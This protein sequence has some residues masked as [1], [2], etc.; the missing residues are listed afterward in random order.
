[1][2]ESK[3]IKYKKKY[4]E[5][6]NKINSNLVDITNQEVQ[7]ID[8][9]IKG[10]VHCTTMKNFKKI[11]KGGYIKSKSSF[12]SDINKWSGFNS[13]LVYTNIWVKTDKYP[14]SIWGTTD[15]DKDDNDRVCIIIDKYILFDKDIYFYINPAGEYGDY[16]EGTILGPN[17]KKLLSS[18]NMEGYIDSLTNDNLKM[19]LIFLLDQLKG[20]KD[21]INKTIDRLGL[22]LNIWHEVCFID[23]IDIREYF[24]GVY[25]SCN[26]I[27]EISKIVTRDMIICT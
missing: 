3:Y 25:T 6:K 8:S 4:L 17:I 9:N 14:E 2:Y 21:T 1:M 18:E 20:S 22:E 23:K 27:D 5:L 16:G 10:L 15:Y 7:Y 19:G 26:N 13:Y 11:I 12:G 24:I